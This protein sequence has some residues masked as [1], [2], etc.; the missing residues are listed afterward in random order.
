MVGAIDPGGK[1]EPTR[2]ATVG[3]SD[4]AVSLAEGIDYEKVSQTPIGRTVKYAEGKP[5]A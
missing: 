2:P 1:K 4:A 3:V 5:V